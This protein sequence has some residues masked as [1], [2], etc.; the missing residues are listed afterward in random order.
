MT[1]TARR[2]RDHP[3]DA[4]GPA[5]PG[6]P[7]SPPS[8]SRSAASSRSCRCSPSTLGPERARRASRRTRRSRWP[9]ATSTSARAA[10]PATRRWSGPPAPRR[11]ATATWTRAGRV[12]LR[13]PVPARLPPD[14]A[15]PAA[16]GRQVP[17]RLAL[18]AHARPAQH[19][20]GQH[21]ADLRVAAWQQ[22]V[23]PARRR[24]LGAR[25]PDGRRAVRRGRRSPASPSSHARQGER[26]R[27]PARAPAG[28][29]A[30]RDEEIVALIAY[31]Q[32][33]GRDGRAAISRRRRGHRRRRRAMN[34][35]F[36]AAAARPSQ[37]GWM[38][39]VLTRGV[40][41]CF[42][43]AGPWWAW[44]A[45]NRGALDEAARLP[46]RTE[47]SSEQG[48]AEPDAR[49]RRRRTT[50]SRST[51]T[52]CRTG[53]WGCSSAHDLLGVRLRGALPLR[54]AALAR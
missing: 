12:R 51:T 52:R 30:G 27:R 34:P 31:L 17:G 24:G 21:H 48:R 42:A 38:L 1:T 9:D 4:R 5:A 45:R 46:F 44:S 53:G 19:V 47:A 37:L 8:R 11:C 39:G 16:G 14:R 25:A 43:R 28:I 29:T 35:V 23:D 18:R 20:A 33:L 26:D 32:R 3:P 41:V 40:P 7:C 54:R 49:P 6:S 2:P 10:T 50:A 15:R 13:P 36:R 22:R